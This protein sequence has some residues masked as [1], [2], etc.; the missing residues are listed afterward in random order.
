ME[1]QAKSVVGD[2]K[3]PKLKMNGVRAAAVNAAGVTV[4]TYFGVMAIFAAIAGFT[5]GEWTFGLPALMVFVPAY[6]STASYLVLAAVLTLVGGL[7]GFFT[8][9]KL[10]DAAAVKKVWNIIGEIFM[11]I[12]GVLALSAV[13]TAIFSIMGIGKKAGVDQGTLWLSTFLPTVIRF[14]TAGTIAFLAKKI[15]AGKLEVLKIFSI[16]AALIAAVALILVIVQTMVSFYAKK[17]SSSRY[18][19]D[20]DWSSLYDY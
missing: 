2:V 8:L 13:T 16:V 10:T 7:I 14:A 6:G 19:D 20:D 9:K 12:A 17:S 4:A 18:Y 5:K 1:K 15:A 11:V 3:M